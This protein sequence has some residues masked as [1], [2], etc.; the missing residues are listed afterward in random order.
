MKSIILTM[1]ILCL[2]SAISYSQLQVDVSA[3]YAK[4]PTTL[5]LKANGYFIFASPSLALNDKF[6][7]HAALQFRQEIR[8]SIVNISSIDISPAIE[9]DVFNFLSVSG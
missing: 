2:H 9:Y 3:G 1:A 4:R 8:K 7:L 5:S 6:R